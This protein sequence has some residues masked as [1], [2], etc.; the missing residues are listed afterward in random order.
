[1]CKMNA[2]VCLLHLSDITSSHNQQ[3]ARDNSNASQYQSRSNERRKVLT[4]HRTGKY[5]PYASNGY[6]TIDNH[7]MP[8]KW[9]A[10]MAGHPIPYFHNDAGHPII[11]IGARK[12]M[13]VG[14]HPPFDHPHEF[15]DMGD[16]TEIV[17][18]YCSTLYRFRPALVA[19]ETIP[20]GCVYGEKVE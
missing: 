1:M 16:D 19:D 14:A 5:Y 11:E 6:Y 2:G 18:P 20:A 13:C 10:R 15:L 4:G 7:E 8:L 3:S 17:C 12:F 9:S